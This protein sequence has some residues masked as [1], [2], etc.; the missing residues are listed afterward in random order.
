MTASLAL[1]LPSLGVHDWTAGTT[2]RAGYAVPTESATAAKIAF[3]VFV[4]ISYFVRMTGPLLLHR[5]ADLTVLSEGRRELHQP[6]PGCGCAFGTGIWA[7][8]AFSQASS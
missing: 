6:R 3:Q 1:K 4:S 2:L 5:S 7:S 8:T